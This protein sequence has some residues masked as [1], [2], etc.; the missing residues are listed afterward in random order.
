MSNYIRAKIAGSYYFFTVVTYQRRPI[1]C[2][3]EVRTALRFAIKQTQK[4]YPFEMIAVV[5]LPDHLHCIWQLPENDSNF[6]IRWAMI[7][8]LVSKNIPQY[9]LTQTELSPSQIKNFEKGIW[10]RR[11]YEHHIRNEQDLNNHLN[12]IHYNP[13]KHGL[14]SRPKD[15]QFSTFY[16]YVQ[17]GFYDEDWGNDIEIIGDF[18]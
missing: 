8:R 5:L 17:M 15:W 2:D 13:V 3:D 11:F 18:E 12:Y 16:K 1:L 4:Q 6:S 14:V 9:H 7:K 10:Q